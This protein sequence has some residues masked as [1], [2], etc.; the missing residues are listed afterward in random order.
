VRI[1]AGALRGRR[2]EAPRG[3]STRPTGE[4]V[5][6][7]VFNLLGQ[8]FDGGAAL[9]L[10]AGS[11]ALALEALSR[12]CATAV[13]VDAD[14]RAAEAIRRNAEACGVAA[15][16]EVRCEP[17]EAA[18]GRLP[19]GRFALAFVDA[20]YAEGPERALAR[21][22]ALLAAGGACVA[23]HDARRPPADAWPGLAL[24][25]RRTYGGTGISIYRRV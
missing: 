24:E 15:R 12:G 11:G 14:R 19:P 16:V 23:E 1:V 20:P 13:C 4:K 3:M 25:E 5:R 22:G 18:L 10:Y 17:V 2:L 6:G 7:A 8:F 21:L 9:D